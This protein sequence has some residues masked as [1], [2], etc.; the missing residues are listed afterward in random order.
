MR[1]HRRL[2][3]RSILFELEAIKD[4]V[5]RGFNV[6]QNCADPM[7]RGC[8]SGF[9]SGSRC[10]GFV[11]VSSGLYVCRPSKTDRKHMGR[12][13]LM[14]TSPGDNVRDAEGDDLREKDALRTPLGVCLDSRHEEP[15]FP[16]HGRPCHQRVPRPS[17]SRQVHLHRVHGDG[18]LPI[19]T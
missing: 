18:C 7:N 13:F 4:L 6:L 1:L 12:R 11:K 10:D 16:V 2:I 14:F 15:C 5:E 17:R 19:Q 3:A 8:L 9:L